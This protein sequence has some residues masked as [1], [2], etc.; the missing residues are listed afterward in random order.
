MV[1]CV[2]AF[3]RI[4]MGFLMLSTSLQQTSIRRDDFLCAWICWWFSKWYGKCVV[5]RPVQSVSDSVS[6]FRNSEEI[7]CCC[8]FIVTVGT[9]IWQIFISED[10]T[11]MTKVP[12]WNH[13]ASAWIFRAIRQYIPLWAAVLLFAKHCADGIESIIMCVGP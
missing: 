9:L 11:V 2:D 4:F 5:T 12:C 13:S 1:R 8:S 3:Y 7:I 10:C 6:T